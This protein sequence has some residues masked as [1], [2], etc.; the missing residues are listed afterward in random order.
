MRAV[1]PFPFENTSPQYVAFDIYQEKT[2]AERWPE[3]ERDSFA[4]PEPAGD[5]FDFEDEEEMRVRFP[6]VF[7]KFPEG[8]D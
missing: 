3:V 2:G 5:R 6:R 7:T 4:Y 1:L 8:M